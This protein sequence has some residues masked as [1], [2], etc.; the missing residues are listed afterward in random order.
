MTFEGSGGVLRK[1]ADKESRANK[2]GKTKKGMGILR[3][4]VVSATIAGGIIGASNGR[5][6]DPRATAVEEQDRHGLS[7]L[8]EAIEKDAVPAQHFGPE[9]FTEQELKCLTDNVYHE[10]RGEGPK[11]QYAVMFATLERSLSKKYPK[12]LCGVV[13]QHLQFSWTSD[14]TILAQPINPHD[15][16]KAAIEVHNLMQGRDAHAAAVEAGLRAG[17]PHGAIFYKAAN[18]T[19]SPQV[20]K[21]FAHLQL[22]ASI[23]NHD[24]YIAKQAGHKHKHGADAKAP[25]FKTAP[26]LVPSQPHL[27]RR[28]GRN[29]AG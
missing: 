25:P 26:S 13:H 22:V 28:A 19:G 27:S 10:A 20:K 23:G 2:V 8:I 12:S 21:F 11:G 4:A 5:K 18:F 6:E 24:F 9:Y 14:R 1:S 16:L 29:H 7:H 15:Y 3:A 17:L